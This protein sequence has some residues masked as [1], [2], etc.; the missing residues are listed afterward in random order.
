M[1]NGVE[2]NNLQNTQE[3]ETLKY[4]CPCKSYLV[5]CKGSGKC[6]YYNKAIRIKLEEDRR[7]F[8]PVARTSYKWERIYKSRTSAE[9]VNSRIDNVY[10]FE[11]HF[12]RGIKKMEL[13][14]SLSLLVMLVKETAILR[15]REKRRRKQAV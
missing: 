1:Y 9:R 15:E 11:R 3:R 10:G 12:I 8:T 7:R 4:I 5:K 6:P 2:K 13:R 14:C